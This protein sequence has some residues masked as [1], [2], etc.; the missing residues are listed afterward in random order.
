MHRSGAPFTMSTPQMLIMMFQKVGMWVSVNV[1]SD[2][3]S[4]WSLLIFLLCLSVCL[5][6]HQFVISVNLHSKFTLPAVIITTIVLVFHSYNEPEQDKNQQNDMCAQ[7]I[8]KS[9]WASAQ[10][11]QSLPC[12]HK[13]NLG[14]Y[15][16]THWMHS[17]DWSGCADAQTESSQGA[18]IILLVQGKVLLWIPSFTLVN[19]VLY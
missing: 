12:P 2:C 19:R 13:E 9:A 5:S 7:R 11:D 4:S 1:G 8:L 10:S 15:L 14:L 18:H 3:I 6:A 17:E 16:G